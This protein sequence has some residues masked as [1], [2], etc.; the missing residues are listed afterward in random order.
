MLEGDHYLVLKFTG[1][2]ELTKMIPAEY[3]G[4]GGRSGETPRTADTAGTAGV[5][6]SLDGTTTPAVAA[7][8]PE[9]GADTGLR[10]Y[11]F[12]GRNDRR[13][14]QRAPGSTGNTG[15]ITDVVVAAT[16]AFRG[17]AGESA[18]VWKIVGPAV[19]A[20]NTISIDT[21]IRVELGLGDEAGEEGGYL[22]VQ[23]TAAGSYGYEIYVY[24]ELGDARVAARSATAPD[25]YVYS[26]D[27]NLF[28]TSSSLATAGAEI[29]ANLLTAD[30]AHVNG[31]FLGFEADMATMTTA[32]V[33]NL[34]M[35]MLEPDDF[36]DFLDT[37]AMALTSMVLQG[38]NIEVTTMAGNFGFGVG[39]G[40]GPNGEVRIDG[41]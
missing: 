13:C 23:G 26:A 35:I 11:T 2:A 33:G 40:D 12:D 4:V 24:E 5:I 7:A 29:T 9:V 6:A 22:A 27:G 18:A 16:R 36:G 21:R 39:A 10:F 25:N 37:N 15:G 1:G 8:D 3:A 31:P 20:V 34:A 28:S 38:A 19:G 17:T 32:D 30:V 41:R 14:D